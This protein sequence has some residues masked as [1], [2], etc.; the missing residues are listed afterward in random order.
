[1]SQYC[2]YWLWEI[3]NQFFD[4]DK[5]GQ[6]HVKEVKNSWLVTFFY[7]K[8]GIRFINLVLFDLWFRNVKSRKSQSLFFWRWINELVTEIGCYKL[9]MWY[10]YQ[11]HVWFGVQFRKLIKDWMVENEQC[12]SVRYLYSHLNLWVKVCFW[13]KLALVELKA[14]WSW[15]WKRDEII[16]VLVN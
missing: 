9:N 16:D 12:K 14:R 8:L 15:Y 3:V 2:S 10:E 13:L 11:N 4:F 5:I 1:M 6:E 7:L